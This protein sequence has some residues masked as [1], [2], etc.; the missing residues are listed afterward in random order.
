MDL[1]QEKKRLEEE[2]EVHIAMGILMSFATLGM[3]AV[4]LV[5]NCLEAWIVAG[6][7]GGFSLMATIIGFIFAIINTNKI[8]KIEGMKKMF[9][10]VDEQSKDFRTKMEMEAMEK[11]IYSNLKF[12]D[13]VLR[14]KFFGITNK[15]LQEDFLNES[16]G[17]WTTV[18]DAIKQFE[19]YNF[20]YRVEFETML[21]SY[22]RKQAI[23]NDY[24]ETKPKKQSTVKRG[25]PAQKTGVQKRRGRPRKVI[26]P[27]KAKR[28]RP[29]KKA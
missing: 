13:L 28:G 4:G 16:L 29:R 9:K 21:E 26:Q 25:R 15:K 14:D 2:N 24:A 12:R 17:I 19:R 23:L 22:Q 18:E 3:L 1:E 5:G 10:E 27:V 6:V 20:D 11:R 8:K 7:L